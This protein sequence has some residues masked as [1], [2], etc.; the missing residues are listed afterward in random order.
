MAD[1]RAHAYISGSVQGVS[2]RYYTYHEA[3][4]HGLCG[5]VRN[6]EDGRVEAVF[7]GEKAGIEQVLEWSQNGPPAAMVDSIEV[8]WDEPSE[9]LSGFRVSATASSGDQA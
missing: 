5:W 3:L 6:L 4:K 8:D 7:E 9:S 1:S 2:F